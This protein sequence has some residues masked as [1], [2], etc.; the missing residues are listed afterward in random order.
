VERKLSSRNLYPSQAGDDKKRSCLQSGSDDSLPQFS[1][2]VFVSPC[3]LFDQAVKQKSFRDPGDGSRA[4]VGDEFTD[5]LVLKT[6]DVKLSPRQDFKKLLVVMAEEIETLIASVIL[7]DRIGN[8][9]KLLNSVAGII[10]SRDKFKLTPHF[11]R[12]LF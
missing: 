1:K 4:Q 3:N 2:V 8:F 7:L 5:H 12:R 9:S 11:V 6:P 10:K